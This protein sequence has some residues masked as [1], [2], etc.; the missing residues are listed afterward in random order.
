LSTFNLSDEVGAL[1]YNFEPYARA[2]TI[3]EPSA[4]Q[5]QA[6]RHA[7][8]ELLSSL[9]TPERPTDDDPAVF[10]A[11]LTEFLSRDTTEADEKILQITAD[12]C[13]NQPSFDELQMLP[14]RARQAFLTWLTGVLLIPEA[15]RPATST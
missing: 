12:V 15:Q 14:Y 10:S 3:P 6:F 11:T 1:D 13:S 4:M 2:G 5:I 7:L 9:P 8:G